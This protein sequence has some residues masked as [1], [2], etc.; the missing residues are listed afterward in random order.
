MCLET[1]LSII[2]T[3]A[4]SIGVI[5]VVIA[6]FK[7]SYDKKK[8]LNTATID[9]IAFFRQEIIIANDNFIKYVRDKKQDYVFSRVQ[10]HTPTIEYTRNYFLEESKK[11][12]DLVKE[13][14]TQSM[15]TLILNSITEL[16]LRIKYLGATDHSALNSIKAP[17][18]ELVEIH[19]VILLMQRE[20]FTGGDTYGE[21]LE[22]YAKWKD[23]VDRR[24]QEERIN[25]II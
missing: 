7:Y 16:A 17:F 15:Q 14:N 3:I 12:A 20:V 22:L 18:V 2:Q 9:Q 8:D 23:Q 1:L 13:L 11:Q 4:A 24:S 19:A 6:V 21:V 10:L 25:D 5:A